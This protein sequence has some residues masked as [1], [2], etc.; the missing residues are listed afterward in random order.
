MNIRQARIEDAKAIHSL[1]SGYAELDKMLFLSMA[2]IYENL[3]R[4]TIAEVN[5]EVAGC[6]ALQIVWSDL[7]EI[8][9]LAID[10]ALLRK[11]IGK[12]LVL[13]AIEQAKELGAQ[14]IFT[15]TLE[16]GFFAR[17]GFAEVTKETLPMKVWSWC[18]KCS[19]K[20]NCDEIAMILEVK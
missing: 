9:S 7:A 19:K 10:K 4:F 1:V 5:G 13:A 8:R 6:C 15:L 11:G 3:Q 16:P 12:A 2:D 18:A 20:E 17:I 14:Q